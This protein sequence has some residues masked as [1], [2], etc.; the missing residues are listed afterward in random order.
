MLLSPLDRIWFWFCGLPLWVQLV[1][2][3]LGFWLL[4]PL[5]IWRTSW[6]LPWK[7]ALTLPF[8]LLL[9]AAVVRDPAPAP[10]PASGLGSETPSQEASSSVDEEP[11]VIGSGDDDRDEP[12]GDASID[13]ADEGSG[14]E[15]RERPSKPSTQL[16]TRVVDGD[17]IEVRLKGRIEDVRLI[18]IDT[19]ETVHPTVG[20]ECFGPAASDFSK[21]RLEGEQVRLEYDVERRDRYGRL[22][23]YVWLD[24][25]MFNKTLVAQG[26]ASVSTYPPN[27]RYVDRFL[28]AQRE[29]RSHNRG[30]WAGCT[31][32]VEPEPDDKP[33]QVSGGGGNCDPNYSG[34]CIPAYPPDLDCSEVGATNFRS[35]GSDPHGFDGDGDGY[36]CES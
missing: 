24:G 14:S 12:G 31:A 18:G 6:T 4:V 21:S 8:A 26:F 29:A 36:A 23:A 3:I 19:P 15:K 9:L 27:V 1:G 2:W 28:D 22:L 16:V 17:T 34:A 11:G 35:T 25:V 30:L 7:A 32:E 13:S 33:A 20:V 10:A 5:L